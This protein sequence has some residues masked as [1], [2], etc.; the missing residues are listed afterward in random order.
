MQGDLDRLNEWVV[1]W[2]MDFN[3]DKCKVMNVG[4]KNPHNRYNI[5]RVM[6]NRSEWERDLGVQVSSDLH[7]SKQCI[8]G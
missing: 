8:K 1:K 6:L 2:Q 4:R 5:N 3:I 7:P